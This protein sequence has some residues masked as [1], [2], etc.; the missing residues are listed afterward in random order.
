MARRDAGRRSQG[1]RHGRPGAPARRAVH[2]LSQGR[3]RRALRAL[4]AAAGTLPDAGRPRGLTGADLRAAAGGAGDGERNCRQ[5]RR[6]DGAP[7]R[8][9]QN[10]RD[11]TVFPR[12]FCPP[13]PADRACRCARRTEFRARSGARSG[14]R[15]F[16]CTD[17]LPRRAFEPTQH[18]FPAADRQN[19]VRRDEGLSPPPHES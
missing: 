1:A 17:R 12:S 3:T 9:L 8:G 7:L 6:D 19:P 10:A 18:D 15:A 16:R 5:P 11:P 4:D 13:R 14:E 2:R